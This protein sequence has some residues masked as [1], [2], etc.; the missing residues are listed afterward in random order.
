MENALHSAA[1]RGHE[2]I[3]RLL[4]GRGAYVDA[5]VLGVSAIYAAS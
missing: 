3:V 5:E 2:A 1:E 4:I